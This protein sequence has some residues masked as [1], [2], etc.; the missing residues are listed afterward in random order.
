[1]QF[2]NTE[3]RFCALLADLLDI[4]KKGGADAAAAAVSESCGMEASVRCQ[5][6]DS[7]DI[8][9]DQG[10]SL[11]VYV[12]GKCGSAAT[13]TFTAEALRTVAD[14]ALAI[15]RATSADPHAGLA[16]KELMAAEMRDLQLYHPWDLAPEDAIA[17]AKRA[18]EAAWQAHPSIS[19]EKSDGASAGT[20]RTLSAYANSHGFCAA[21][22]D[23]Y[24]SISCAAV[25]EKDG[26]METDGWGEGKR[27]ADWLPAPEE[28]GAIAGQ[29]TARRLG[30]QKLGDCRAGV[31]FDAQSARSLIGHFA[32][33]AS[34]GSLYRNTSFLLDKLGSQVF[35]DHISIR[36]LPHLP[37]KTGS[38]NYDDDGVA[39]QTRDV[40][41]GGVWEGCFLSAYSAR[42]LGMQTTG[43]AGGSHNLE[44]SG[45]TVP[46]ADLP[47]MLGRGLLVT[48]LMG[49][50]ANITTGDYSRGVAG[51]WVEGGEIAHPVSEVTIAGNLPEMLA[52]ILA[53]GDDAEWR[54]RMK[55][56]SLLLPEMVIGGN[57]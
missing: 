20:S 34:G 26:N 17:L 39:T 12:N 13:A 57:R 36:E 21:E 4:A 6:L 11:T 47:K 56:G 8:N 25:A 14:R 29:R 50:G 15:A 44:V 55:C 48:S 5:K 42:K 2:I 38:C 19:R 9:R 1:M 24:H 10:L 30:G 52:G 53:V 49:Q 54:G 45:S 37:G 18:E 40:V 16:D 35:A 31:L 43:N 41:R 27:S 7:M 3:E 33:A 51:F 32:A 28:I 46:A 22:M 23:T